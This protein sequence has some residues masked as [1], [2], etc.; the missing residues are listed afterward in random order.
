MS[1]GGGA[2]AAAAAGAAAGS[3]AATGAAASTELELQKQKALLCAYKQRKKA[4]G[5]KSRALRTT[6]LEQEKA[7]ERVAA[8][9]LLTE[10]A[11]ICGRCKP[12]SMVHSRTQAKTVARAVSHE[13][14]RPAAFLNSSLTRI[15]AVCACADTD[16]SGTRLCR[17]EV[18][19][20]RKE[21][22]PVVKTGG[23]PNVWVVDKPKAASPTD[24]ESDP[25]DVLA[26]F[27][28]APTTPSVWVCS[29]ATLEHS[30]GSPTTGKGKATHPVRVRAR[31]ALLLLL[32]LAVR[33]PPQY[34][35]HV[36]R[37][38][39]SILSRPSLP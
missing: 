28:A 4:L 2:A 39:R 26:G 38:T 16:G 36:P 13:G 29:K 9:P 5:L 23:P 34:S 22:E 32:V 15:H 12:G 20:E 3:A 30:C 10:L 6:L 1:S 8:P 19:F 37:S 17:F 31:C 11:G 18:V 25:M 14:H 21:K 24:D 27:L 33:G 7:E 35:T